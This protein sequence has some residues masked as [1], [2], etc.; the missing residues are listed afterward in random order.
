[1]VVIDRREDEGA[2]APGANRAQV[3]AELIKG[4]FPM[5]G[6]LESHAVP[7]RVEVADRDQA[8]TANTTIHGGSL[9]DIESTT[10]TDGTPD[11]VWCVTET[12]GPRVILQL[13]LQRIWGTEL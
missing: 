3:Q 6:E 4:Q 8:A 2:Y 9:T 11:G 1:M 5:A 12:P 7:A 10:G 13:L